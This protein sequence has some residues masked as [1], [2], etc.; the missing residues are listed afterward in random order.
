METKCKWL[1]LFLVISLA[2]NLAIAAPYLYREWSSKPGKP[3]RIMEISS[4]MD[5]GDEQKKQ[6]DA[7]VNKFRLNLMQFKQDILE[8]RIDIIDELGDPEFDPAN[9]T[10]HT[11]ELNK[12]QNELNLLFVET[13]MRINTH[14]D[15]EQRLD[16][17]YRLSKHWFFLNKQLREKPKKRGNND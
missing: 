10:A 12:L 11:E 8:K 17:L 2:V 15:S 3:S 1:K 16:F 9:I 5:L 14:L 6:I 4:K 7:I 13:L